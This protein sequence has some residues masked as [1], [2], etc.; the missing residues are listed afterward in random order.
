MAGR[1]MGSLCS[2]YGGLDEAVQQVEGGELVWVAD[3]D[4]GA[5]KILA[6]HHPKV[7]NLGDITVVDWD[8]VPPVDIL[9]MGFPCQDVSVAGLRA[10]M[11][12]GNRSGL[13]FH[14]ARAIAALNPSLVVIENVPGLLAARADGDVEPCAW[15][16]GDGGGEPP[17]R[18]L[19]AVLGDL[20]GLG[21]DAEWTSLPASAVGAC[22]K[23]NRVFIRAWPAD[24]ESTRLEDGWEGRSAREG[25]DA[26]DAQ[27]VGRREGRAEPARVE[28]R[29]RLVGDGGAPTAHPH[30][31]A[32]RE[33]PVPVPGCRSEAVAGLA[34]PEAAAD[35]AHVGRQRGGQHGD[36]GLDLR[37]AVGSLAVADTDG[38]PGAERGDAA[39]GET[40]GG[41]A[42][43]VDCGCDRAPWGSFG[44]AIHRWE[45]VIGRPAPEP[46]DERG[47][48]AV[49]F[50]E[51]MQG[52]PAGH[53]TDVPGL[54]RK[55]MLK[56]LG[57]GVV[58]LQ[59]VA[60]LVVLRER[61]R[62]L[63]AAA[64]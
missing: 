51:W 26:S 49:P 45:Q 28:G 59:A 30:G 42:S 7:P 36:G 52:L 56:A 35:S 60:A 47:R 13:W 10:G 16:L 41:G 27:G 43:A 44:P 1:R 4:P 53:V 23:R 9:T 34:D 40:Q 32:V 64:A 63:L 5:E 22:H 3:N 54:S 6:H 58:T 31:D 57:N 33:Q 17:L 37:T 19:G 2:G 24:S 14:C 25:A 29:P 20:A 48:L 62:T 21:F 15:C 38:E 46:V 12:V 39:P 11:L 61:A 50:V 8:Q 55:A 18:A